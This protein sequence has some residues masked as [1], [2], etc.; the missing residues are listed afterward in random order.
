MLRAETAA[1]TL[2][3]ARAAAR[4]FAEGGDVL[5]Q[6]FLP[7]MRSAAG[8]PLGEVCMVVADGKGIAGPCGIP[9]RA[10]FLSCQKS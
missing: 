7:A 6:P 2:A 9:V 4:L 5:V 8:R 10:F 3:S 1:W